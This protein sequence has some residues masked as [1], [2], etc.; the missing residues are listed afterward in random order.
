MLR[1]KS[2]FIGFGIFLYC[3]TINAD[4]IILPGSTCHP[5]NGAEEKYFQRDSGRISNEGDIRLEVACPLPRIKNDDI[6]D[7]FDVDVRV[8]NELDGYV[9]ECYLIERY[10]A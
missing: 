9:F 6:Y 3:G 10:A 2:L 8:W 5:I 1:T 7:T 4:E